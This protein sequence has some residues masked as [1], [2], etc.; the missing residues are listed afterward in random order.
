MDGFLKLQRRPPAAQSTASEFGRSVGRITR[1]ARLANLAVNRHF[2]GRFVAL[3]VDVEK[4]ATPF[5]RFRYVSGN[6]MLHFHAFAAD[7]T[8]R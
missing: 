3:M 5:Q 8:N 6:A 7:F 4:I 1:S 2:D